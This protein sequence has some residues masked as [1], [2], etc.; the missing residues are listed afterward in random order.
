MSIGKLSFLS[1]SGFSWFLNFLTLRLYPKSFCFSLIPKFPNSKT[2][3]YVHLPILDLQ[4]KPPHAVDF[5]FFQWFHWPLLN[6][7]RI[8]TDSHYGK[9]DSAV[10]EPTYWSQN[11]LIY[12]TY[13]MNFLGHSKYP[14]FPGVQTVRTSLVETQL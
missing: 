8:S 2:I 5:F 11:S 12:S 10:V 13:T 4:S 6:N 3:P 14:D 9:R 1:H 7:K